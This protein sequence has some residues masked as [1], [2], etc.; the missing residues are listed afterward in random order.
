VHAFRGH[1]FVVRLRLC[2]VCYDFP[3][4]MILACDY[5]AW[6]RA[7]KNEEV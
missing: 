5:V 4:I 1:L 3:D 6:E 2:C 7:C